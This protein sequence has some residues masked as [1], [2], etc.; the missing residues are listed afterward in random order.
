MDDISTWLSFEPEK[1]NKW[2]F[3]NYRGKHFM[4]FK[5][6]RQKNEK[7]NQQNVKLLY[8]VSTVNDHIQ[9]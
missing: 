9:K 7:F 6:K 8:G 1:P 5:I 3:C 2:I 4:G